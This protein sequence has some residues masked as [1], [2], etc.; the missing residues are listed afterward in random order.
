M[1]E[2]PVTTS[3]KPSAILIPPSSSP[4]VNGAAAEAFFAMSYGQASFPPRVFVENPVGPQ[5]LATTG[6]FAVPSTSWGTPAKEQGFGSGGSQQRQSPIESGQSAMPARRKA[7]DD[8]V[9]P[10]P[11]VSGALAALPSFNLSALE[12]S[13]EQFLKGLEKLGP[14]L[15][16]EE[17]ASSW[18]PWIVA[19][20]AAATACEITRRELRRLR[21]SADGGEWNALWFFMLTSQRPPQDREDRS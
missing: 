5:G 12:Q 11:H 18:W 6:L 13:I 4:G 9:L 17:S 21:W 3:G 2:P 7:V 16:L 10:A 15:A 19:G 8:V 14:R 20:V 1:F